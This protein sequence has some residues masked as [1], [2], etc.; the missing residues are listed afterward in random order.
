MEIRY[1]DRDYVGDGRTRVYA[2]YRVFEAFRC[3]ASEIRTVDVS[4]A[5][6]RPPVTCT[7]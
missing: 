5:R 2:Q 6:H 1:S 7:A 3:V 4:M